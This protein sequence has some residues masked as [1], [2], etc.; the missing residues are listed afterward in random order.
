MVDGHFF[1]LVQWPDDLTVE[2]PCTDNKA[3]HLVPRRRMWSTLGSILL[4]PMFMSPLINIEDFIWG[5]FAKQGSEPGWVCNSLW[6]LSP[7]PHVWFSFRATLPWLV[8][9]T[10][11]T[12]N[13]ITIHHTPTSPSLMD[14]PSFPGLRVTMHP[15]IQCNVF[16]LLHFTSLRGW[17]CTV[18]HS[19]HHRGVSLHETFEARLELQID[20]NGPG[21]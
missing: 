3:V 14:V 2:F 15:Y 10:H 12:L 9:F 1:L 19:F 17:I 21:C 8:P 5:Q 4:L 20:K 13:L 18:M 7:G 16:Y 11:L 6:L